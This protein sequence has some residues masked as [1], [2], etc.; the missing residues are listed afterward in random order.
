MAK[1]THEYAEEVLSNDD[2]LK[3]VLEKIEPTEKEQI[4]SRLGER[5]MARDDYSRSLD[6][7]RE[8]EAANTAYKATL[9][10]WFTEKL[11]DL[12][13]GNQARAELEKLKKQIPAGGDPNAGS[14]TIK[15]LEGYLKKDEAEK[16]FVAKLRES[17]EQGLQIY[18]ELT[19]IGLQHMHEY[20]KPI[21][22]R[23][24]V[25]LARQKGITA[26]AAYSELS[27]DDRTAAEKR[28]ADAHEKKLREEIE[29]KVRSEMG[30]GVFPVSPSASVGD[31]TLS[32]LRG[33]GKAAVGVSAAIDDFYKNSG[34][35]RAS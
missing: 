29:N 14:S 15:D 18:T 32:A 34:A 8:K 3:K 4:L 26:A 16:A 20:G 31:S 22:P 11:T 5:I 25:N 7:L 21:D 13:G 12:E 35:R 30:H 23:A 28:K 27:T 10:N 9:D 2:Y 17:E 33:D 19:A 1:K 24:I 6:G